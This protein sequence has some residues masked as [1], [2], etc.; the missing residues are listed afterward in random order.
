MSGLLSRRQLPAGIAIAALVALLTA[1]AGLASSPNQEKI[2]LTPAGNAQAKAEVLRKSDLPSG[3][4]GGAKKPSLS[5][6]M[7]CSS[8]HPKQS[9]LTLVG[10]AESAFQRSG[11]Q[12]DSEAQVLKTPKMVQLDWQRTAIDPRVPAC[13]RQ[14]FVKTVGSSGKVVSFK[15]AAFPKVAAL[16]HA[17]RV[18]VDVKTANGSV[19]IEFD[20]AL[21]GAGRNEITLSLTG[22]AAAHNSLHTVLVSLA[23][24]LA[25]RMR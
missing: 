25:A 10:A 8:Y 23:R 19:P 13:L 12:V 1:G 17:F 7:P 4:K 9:D 15:S 18:V 24:V 20:V 14:G 22:P 16:T 11:L 3:W 5:S 6:T 2:A 21:V